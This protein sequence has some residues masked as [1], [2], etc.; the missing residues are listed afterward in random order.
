MMKKKI[1]LAIAVFI[2]MNVLGCCRRVV[3]DDYVESYRYKPESDFSY[4][5]SL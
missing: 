3:Y 4:V 5:K 2:I 1:W